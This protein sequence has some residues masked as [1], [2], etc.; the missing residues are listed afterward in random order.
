MLETFCLAGGIAAGL[1][2]G[3]APSSGSHPEGVR[4]PSRKLLYG[5][6]AV[7]ESIDDTDN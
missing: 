3:V 7:T 2:D 6:D 5:N 1:S 4:I